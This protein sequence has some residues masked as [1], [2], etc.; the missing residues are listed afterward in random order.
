MAAAAT[1][2]GHSTMQ[3][4]KGRFDEYSLGFAAPRG[5]EGVGGD[6]GVGNFGAG[7]A[8]P[9][10]HPQN[11][12][13]RHLTGRWRSMPAPA[14]RASQALAHPLLELSAVAPGSHTHMWQHAV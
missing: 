13:A 7:A 4:R 11:L 2:R 14:A 3:G 6:D 9:K 12:R 5:G 10:M 8:A 1:Q